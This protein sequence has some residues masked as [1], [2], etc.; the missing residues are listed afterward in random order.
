MPALLSFAHPNFGKSNSISAT[1]RKLADNT[2]STPSSRN[3]VLRSDIEPIYVSK[4]MED[5][6]VAQFTP[7]KPSEQH[8]I[9]ALSPQSTMSTADSNNIH[10]AREMMACDVAKRHWHTCPRC[11]RREFFMVLLEMISYI[12]MGVLIITAMRSTQ[13]RF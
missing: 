11:R 9:T 7:P 10:T 8:D 6:N 2:F 4:D 1:T 5:F 3:A 12:L 13:P